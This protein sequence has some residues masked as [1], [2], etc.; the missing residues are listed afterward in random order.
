MTEMEHSGKPALASKFVSGVALFAVV[1]VIGLW[2]PPL[3]WCALILFSIA[4]AASECVRMLGRASA[5]GVLV[6][7]VLGLTL[8]PVVGG[9]PQSVPLRVSCYLATLVLTFVVAWRLRRNAVA[10]RPGR[11]MLAGSVGA[12]G[13]LLSCGLL[14]AITLRELRG[15]PWLV[16]LVVLAAWSGDMGAGV[17]TQRFVPTPTPMWTWASPRKNWEGTTFGAASSTAAVVL[18]VWVLEVPIPT[19]IVA[20]IV[21][22]SWFCRPV[23]D[24]AES[25][26]K[27]LADAR[28]SGTYRVVPEHGGVFDRI[29]SLTVAFPVTYLVVSDF[30]GNA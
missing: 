22:A 2:A 7:A 11:G 12:A 13:A 15:G 16:T 20:R 21:V 4:A 28:D 27:R 5:R 18:V 3:L 6:G 8:L 29:D 25:A 10:P 26:I 1:A 14:A 17:L 24:L 19:A 9:S 30:I 23:G